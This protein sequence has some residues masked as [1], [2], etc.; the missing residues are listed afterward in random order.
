[1]S[2]VLAPAR[3][4]SSKWSRSNCSTFQIRARS[5]TAQSRQFLV[6]PGGTGGG[7]IWAVSS[8]CTF[9]RITAN[10]VR[11]LRPTAPRAAHDDDVCLTRSVP[12]IPIIDQ[13]AQAAANGWTENCSITVQAHVQAFEIRY[14]S[15]KSSVRARR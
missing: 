4:G 2:A 7:E 9:F 1:M 15:R 14:G 8:G 5:L 6:L 10:A 12:R 11:S 3:D 13:A